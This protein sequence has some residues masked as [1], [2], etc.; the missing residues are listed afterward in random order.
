MPA[1]LLKP[2]IHASTEKLDNPRLFIGQ[3]IRFLGVLEDVVELDGR[4]AVFPRNR[5]GDF[6][7]TELVDMA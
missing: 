2:G 4:L 5:V 6:V 1:A 3:V 7:I